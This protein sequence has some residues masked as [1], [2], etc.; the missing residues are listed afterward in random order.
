MA[1]MTVAKYDFG[2]SPH[3]CEWI[4][5]NDGGTRTRPTCILIPFR[6]NI[7]IRDESHFRELFDA[8]ANALVSQKDNVRLAFSW[9]ITIHDDKI[10]IKHNKH[11]DVIQLSDVV[12]MHPIDNHAYRIVISLYDGREYEILFPFQSHLQSA[13]FLIL[14]AFRKP[15]ANTGFE[16][17]AFGNHAARQIINVIR[18]N[19][20]GDVIVREIGNV[21]YTIHHSRIRLAQHCWKGRGGDMIPLPPPH[22]TPSNDENDNEDDNDND[23][24]DMEKKVVVRDGYVWWREGDTFRRFNLL[25]TVIPTDIPPYAL[26]VI[27]MEYVGPNATYDETTGIYYGNKRIAFPKKHGYVTC[28]L[29]E[30]TTH[31]ITKFYIPDDIDIRTNMKDVLDVVSKFWLKK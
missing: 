13:F 10:H 18:I 30:H 16:H 26:H 6:P 8:L 5:K 22:P 3:R 12:D 29:Y 4:S 17:I 21:H 20:D 9:N 23:N 19:D 27:M 7:D 25:S 1:V 31:S 15:F 14:N 28:K 24:D 2:D 11:H